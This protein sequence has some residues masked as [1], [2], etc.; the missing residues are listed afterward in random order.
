MMQKR[1]KQNYFNKFKEV[2]KDES[3]VGKL[4]RQFVYLERDPRL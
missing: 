1:A 3:H 2:T 4:K